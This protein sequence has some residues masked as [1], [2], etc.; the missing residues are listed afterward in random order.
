M[1]PI[2][3]IES[4]VVGVPDD[5]WGERLRAFVVPRAG[6]LRQPEPLLEHCRTLLSSYKVPKEIRFIETIP[7]NLG[8]KVLKKELRNVV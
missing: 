8:G 1:L 3:V 4:A 7:R 6:S 2:D 5:H